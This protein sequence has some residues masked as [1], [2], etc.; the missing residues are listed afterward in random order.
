MLL[1]VALLDF[2]GYSVITNLGSNLMVIPLAGRS[3][4]VPGGGGGI[5]VG[6][7]IVGVIGGWEAGGSVAGGGII[8]S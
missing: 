8:G 5:S 3:N 2:K 4:V 1:T 6:G 7:N